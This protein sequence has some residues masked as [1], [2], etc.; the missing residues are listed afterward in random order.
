[1]NDKADKVIVIGG[2][3]AGVQAALDLAD[4]GIKTYIIE[5]SPSIGGRMA[6][7]DKTFPTNDCSMCILSPKLVAA[8]RHPNIT[9]ITHAELKE[10][11]G[12]EGNF[13][14]KIS[15]RPRYVD[16]EKCT[17]CG[18][19]AQACPVKIES[20]FDQGLGSRSA[21]Y[22]PF[23][24]AVPLKYSIQRRGTPPCQTTCP[25]G[26]HSQGYIA[27]ISQGKYKEALESHR[28]YNPLPLI[29]GRVCP[30]PCEDACNRGEVDSPIAISAL[31]RF[32]ADWELEHRDEDFIP[33]E[34]TS[35]K[36]VAVIGSGP[37]GLSCAYYVAKQGHT[38]TIFESL[39]VAGGMLA[40]GIPE[41]R[42][43]KDI[44]NAEIDYIKKKGVEIRLNTEFGKDIT[45]ESLKTEGYD[46]V[47]LG[48]GAHGSKRL[49]ISGEDLEGVIPG[50]EFLRS[51]NLGKEA[52]IGKR[53][54]VI[55]GGDVA[56]DSVRVATRKGSD[57]FILYR[58]T[59]NEMP[60]HSSE[61]AATE[62]EGIEIQFL[63]QPVEILGENGKVVGV[64]CI[65]MELG[66][67][68]ESGR[69]RPVPI[70]GSEFTIEVDTIMPA[71]GQVPDLSFAEELDLNLSK[72]GTIIVD[73]KTYSTNIDGV[74][75]A[76]DVQ[77]GPST[78]VS[79]VGAARRA[80][81][82]I[83]AYLGGEKFQGE[84]EIEDVVAFEDL[85][86]DEKIETKQRVMEPE[87]PPQKRK[88]N[89]K[90]VVSGLSEEEAKSEALRCLNCGICSGCY[91]CIAAC[92]PK[93]VDFTQTEEEIKL[94]VS[95][96]V[97]MPGYDD[98]NPMTRPEYGYDRYDNVITALEFER[99][100][101]A[102]GPFVGHIKRISDSEEPKTMAFIQCVGSR[103]RNRGVGYCSSVCCMYA[104]KEAIIAKEHSPGLDVTIFH[105]D[106]RAFG[107]EFDY[108]YQRAQDI[109]I[110]FVRCRV[111]NITENTDRNLIV[112]FVDEKKEPKHKTFDMVVL[113]N[114]IGKPESYE[115]LGNA[116]GIDLNE[117]GFC[118]T[119][120]F[121]PLA[122]SRKGVYVG[123]AFSEPKD[124]PDSVAQASGAAGQASVAISVAGLRIPQSREE[125]P[126][127]DISSEEPRV[128]VFICHCGINIGNTVDVPGVV[129]YAKT[130]PNVVYAEN[131]LYTCS[132]DTQGAI[133][134]KIAEHN[135]NR[136]VVAACSPRTHEPLFQSTLYEAELNRYLF[137]MANIRDQC[138]WVHQKDPEKATAKAKDLVRM[139]VANA[140]LLS[141]LYK[142]KIP[143][144]QSALVIGGGL[145]GMNAALGLAAQ[146]YETHLV[147][148][149]SQLGGNLNNLY[150]TVDGE[151]AQKHL[152]DIISKVEVNDGI[153]VNME[154]EVVSVDGHI[155]NFKVTIKSGEEQNTIYVGAII[156]STGAK[157]Y[158][159]KEYLYGEHENVMTQHE[160]EEKLAKGESDFSNVVMIQCV[161]SRNE[162]R[163]YC[164]RVCCTHAVKNA[165]KLK[166]LRPDSEIFVLY[167]D[168]RTY[169]F[170]EDYYAKASD[171]GVKFIRYDDEKLPIVE[172]GENGNI[173]ISVMDRVLEKPLIFTPDALVLSAAIIP[174]EDNLKLSQLLKAQLSRDK[175]FLEAHMKLSPVDFSTE[176]MFLCGLAHS[177]KFVNE[178]LYQ[179][180][181]AVARACTILSK[182]H[183]EVGGVISEVEEGKCVACLTCVRTCPY[184]VPSIN[185]KGVA[186]IDVATCRG[187]GI[188]AAEC[189]VKAIQLKH[190]TDSQILQK[191]KALFEEGG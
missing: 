94:A 10:L 1:M 123:G 72:Q 99:I 33:F 21:A 119:S 125:I 161:G 114:G 112:N 102:S 53:V 20:E 186:K 7:L 168:M 86:L 24:Q 191:A 93:A 135:L 91:Q 52:P 132:V 87:L 3:I 45:L 178:S 174:N 80:A 6:Q 164:S 35:E 170:R 42:L 82:A 62:K 49:A 67:P 158:K 162:E 89:F 187:C 124:I 26:V 65:K 131:N 27:L 156:V 61:I 55:G 88:G 64:K 143:V 16:F 40:V 30:H 104:I 136:V 140:K 31:K 71:I 41:Y 36:K 76:G 151:D 173:K 60:A 12:E 145:S 126:E 13:K 23:P 146:G 127:K 38:P 176:G 120:T 9:I 184:Y 68:D 75:S 48:V 39:P 122:S 166:E 180:S 183:L 78:V 15:R 43:P 108:Y 149:E 110:K 5:K 117:Y 37:A 109:G 4:S 155:G 100:L 150:F 46:A 19:C 58:R 98:L 95:S 47:F 74:F 97:V 121:E 79:A 28:E 57:A 22:I 172:K 90:E 106:I 179:A 129:E 148:K 139:A 167:K 163:P 175:F 152:N 137:E 50:V 182:D 73:E 11:S 85:E 115:K 130:L 51:V 44:L 29:C 113:S 181:G 116:L 81:S 56:I 133:K 185:E 141:P 169:G 59:R 69:R 107:K 32:M 14:A 138:S 101:S 153:H 17:A 118:K 157:E 159:P 147:E 142:T 8:G 190:Y 188:C 84:A 2:G 92:E 25:A 165:L 160:F 83:E 177:P 134:E 105:M 103:D 171:L 63:T 128:G 54:A 96:V 66:E 189:P 18:L 111:A 154:S 77:S 34:K 70:E 144:V